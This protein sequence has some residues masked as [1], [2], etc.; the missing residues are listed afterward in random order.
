[1]YKVR[2]S[3]LE[4]CDCCTLSCD[5]HTVIRL[6]STQT[7]Q[8][9]LDVVSGHCGGEIGEGEIGDG[10]IGEGERGSV[11]MIVSSSLNSSWVYTNFCYG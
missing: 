4:S 3:T 10:E 1:M 6:Y 5:H 11:Y 7:V 9:R 2:Y 8:F